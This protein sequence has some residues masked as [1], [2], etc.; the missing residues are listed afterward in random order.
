MKERPDGTKYP[1]I[2]MDAEWTPGWSSEDDRNGLF[3]SFG[4]LDFDEWDQVT[5]RKSSRRLKDLFSPYYRSRKFGVTENTG[6]S[7]ADQFVANLTSRFRFN[8]ASKILPPSRKK[9]ARSNPFNANGDMC[10]KPD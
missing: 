9:Q 6:P 4:Y 1:E 3:S 5:M 10:T 7:A 8:V 2:D